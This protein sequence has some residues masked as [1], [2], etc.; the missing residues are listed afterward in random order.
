MATER[1]LD[2]PALVE[3][4]QAM[5]VA[6]ATY[7]QIRRELR[8]G[9]STVSRL[10][11]TQGASRTEAPH[12][13]CRTGVRR[14]AAC[15]RSQHPSHCPRAWDCTQQRLAADPPHQAD[16]GG[17]S[18]ARRKEAGRAYW[19]KE[20]Q[21]RAL[22]RQKASDQA[23]SRVVALTEREL[24]LGAVAYWAEGTKA[25]PWRQ[26]ERLSFTNSDPNMIKLF[27]AWLNLV[28]VDGER[29]RFRVHIH[30]SADIGGALR[31]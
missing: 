15:R 12:A 14:S 19:R 25:K 7:A 20:N 23:A 22:V 17:E 1:L 6:G 24:L 21:R 4:A 5:R 3:R 9:T 28:G 11:G 27:L 18:A 31:Y 30:E 13:D 26:Q 8:V 29:L 2:H 16:C 10:L